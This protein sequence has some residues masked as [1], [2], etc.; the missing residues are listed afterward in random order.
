MIDQELLVGTW[1]LRGVYHVAIRTTSMTTSSIR[2]WFSTPCGCA[3]P[4]GEYVLDDWRVAARPDGKRLKEP[5]LFKHHV[6][7]LECLVTQLLEK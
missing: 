4:W 3:T 6:T 7:C 1:R 2:M 5:R